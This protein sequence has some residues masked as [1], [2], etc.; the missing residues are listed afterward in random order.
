MSSWM[1]RGNHLDKVF[2]V[3]V[4]VLFVAWLI[5]DALRRR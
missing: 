3:A 1:Q 5:L 2:V 4:M